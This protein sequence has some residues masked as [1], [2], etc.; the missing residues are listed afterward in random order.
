MSKIIKLLIAS[1]MVANFAAPITAQA[2]QR[3]VSV[4]CSVAVNVSKPEGDEIYQKDF[5]VQPDVNFSDD[6]STL[7]RQKTFDAYTL[8]V[9]GRTEVTI[10]YFN[11]VGVFD[12]L[13]F[14]TTFMLPQDRE[15]GSI[16]GKSAAFTSNGNFT[17]NY[18]LTCNRN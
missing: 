9:A 14:N 17:A 13:Q 11:D 18:T 6:F 3:A 16:S 4:S 15:A 2:K 7:I 8:T 1:S 5:V 10:D 12:A